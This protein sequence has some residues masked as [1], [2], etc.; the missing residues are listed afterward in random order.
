MK[1]RRLR[2]F[3]TWLHAVDSLGLVTN[4]HKS[5]PPSCYWPVTPCVL[6]SSVIVISQQNVR[7]ISSNKRCKWCSLLCPSSRRVIPIRKWLENSN[8][9]YLIEFPREIPCVKNS[10]MSGTHYAQFPQLISGTVRRYRA[11]LT[12]HVDKPWLHSFHCV[13]LDTIVSYT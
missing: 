13:G 9:L 10:I 4:T 7:N 2:T 11:P 3:S 8:T 5:F 12:D 6:T 1:T